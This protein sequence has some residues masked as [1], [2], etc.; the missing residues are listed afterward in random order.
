V[1]T[2]LTNKSIVLTAVVLGLIWSLL[3]L[4]RSTDP[5]YGE[6]V[7][8]SQALLKEPKPGA[9]IKLREFGWQTRFKTGLKNAVT[10]CAEKT[11]VSKEI[12][13]GFRM[14]DEERRSELILH[15][16]RAIRACDRANRVLPPDHPLSRRVSALVSAHRAELGDVRLSVK[17]YDCTGMN[18]FS[19]PD[20]SIRFDKGVLD[21]LS[22]AE[23]LALFGHE[24]GHVIMAHQ[25]KQTKWASAVQLFFFRAPSRIKPKLIDYLNTVVSRDHEFRA[26]DFSFEWASHHGYDLTAHYTIFGKLADTQTA[27]GYPLWEERGKRIQ[28]KLIRLQKPKKPFFR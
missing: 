11:G 15:S 19:S 23:I 22:D 13:D 18:A 7:S 20:G 9:Q 16:R 14:T 26:D 12:I 6:L 21:R 27:P 25:E 10:Y 1:R 2:V 5:G 3:F 8:E 28:D 24:L 4:I 17:I